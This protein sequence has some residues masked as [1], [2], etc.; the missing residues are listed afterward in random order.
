MP[1]TASGNQSSLSVHPSSQ[2]S[3][4]PTVVGTLDL[5]GM[6]VENAIYRLTAF[7]EE[8][9]R[10]HRGR[11]NS[12][13]RDL[14]VKII[15]GTGS[16]SA[17]GPAIRPAVESLLKRRDMRFW[18]DGGKGSFTVVAN[19]GH[20]FYSNHNRTKTDTKVLFKSSDDEKKKAGTITGAVPKVMTKITLDQIEAFNSI[21]HRFPREREDPQPHEVKADD[22]MLTRVKNISVKETVERS[23]N[24]RTEDANARIALTHSDNQQK[25]LDSE[26]ETFRKALELSVEET[27]KTSTVDDSDFEAALRES[28]LLA[29]KHDTKVDWSMQYGDELEKALNLSVQHENEMKSK[30]IQEVH[31]AILASQQSYNRESNSRHVETSP[32]PPRTQSSRF[33]RL[34]LTS[35]RRTP[36]S[37]MS[38]NSEHFSLNF[39]PTHSLDTTQS[40]NLSSDEPQEVIRPMFLTKTSQ[41][42]SQNQ[43]LRNDRERSSQNS[44]VIDYSILGL[45]D[46]EIRRLRE[47]GFL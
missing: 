32:K 44:D 37:S 21:K 47:E 5:H 22:N 25:A 10:N 36:V 29:D 12:L 40:T 38:P 15:T 1:N 46:H 2:S 16:H 41:H 7:L 23:N 17:N 8:I 3:F 45:P 43:S 18:P 42:I 6:T 35:R 20:E 27:R 11:G 34:D 19:S 28:Q 14:W 4:C 33:S 31:N 13:D 9:V 26:E 24:A 39:A 30:E